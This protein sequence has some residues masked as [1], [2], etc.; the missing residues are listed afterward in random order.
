MQ[1]SG[2]AHCHQ[3]GQA[4]SAHCSLQHDVR[5]GSAGSVTPGAVLIA[6]VELP[7]LAIDLASRQ[8]VALLTPSPPVLFSKATPLPLRI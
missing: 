5:V 7:V 8:C 1:P 3:H 2:G 6:M 4:K